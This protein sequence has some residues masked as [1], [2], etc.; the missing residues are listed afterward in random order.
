MM[1]IV[2]RQTDRLLDENLH[3]KDISANDGATKMGQKMMMLYIYER[4]SEK[5]VLRTF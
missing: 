1:V 2:D 3:I 5:R 4:R